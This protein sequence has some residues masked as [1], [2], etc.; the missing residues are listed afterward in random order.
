MDKTEGP[1]HEHQ[2]WRV[3]DIPTGGEMYITA[4][5]RL[6]FVDQTGMQVAPLTF[7]EI[8]A[9]CPWA[10]DRDRGVIREMSAG[11]ARGLR[12]TDPMRRAPMDTER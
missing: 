7:T 5:S 8:I 4:L 10:T 6:G 1:R 11:Y 9:G 2:G 12:M 3:P